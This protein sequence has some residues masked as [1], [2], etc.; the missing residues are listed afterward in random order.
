MNSLQLTKYAF[1]FRF[2]NTTVLPHFMGNTFRG[3]F[4]ASLEKIGS[5]MYNDVFK[6][7]KSESIPNPY[8]ISVPYPGKGKYDIG[9]SITFY[10]TLVGDACLYEEELVKTVKNMNMGKLENSECIDA[11]IVFSSTWSDKGAES[12][13]LCERLTVR[14]LSPTE[15]LR[16]KAP[17]LKPDFYDFIDS[18]F[19][20]IGG[21]IDNYT[22]NLF[23]LPYSYITAKPFV[24]AEYDLKTVS[25]QTHSGFTGTIRYYGDVTRYLP[26]I[27]LCGQIHIGKK[28]TRS[29][30][31][32]EFELD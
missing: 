24:T 21:I 31:E 2:T 26:Y 20:R 19:I 29:C 15:I 14:F 22:S 28:T 1:S 18:V 7:T 12:I 16:K 5:P 30:G 9:D 25:L 17:I 6:V 27:D 23:V 4:G 3:A 13:P 10:I 32:Y 8:V 11:S